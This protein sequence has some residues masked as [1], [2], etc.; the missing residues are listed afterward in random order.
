MHAWYY[1]ENYGIKTLWFGLKC[2]SFPPPLYKNLGLW[3]QPS[4]L[5]LAKIRRQYQFCFVKQMS[6][7]CKRIAFSTQEGGSMYYTKSQGV[8]FVIFSIIVFLFHVATIHACYLN[9]QC[10]KIAISD[11]F[12]NLHFK[13]S[14]SRST[15]SSSCFISWQKVGSEAAVSWNFSRRKLPNWV[16][17][18]VQG[19]QEY[20]NFFV[21]S[22]IKV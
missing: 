19:M 20:T 14:R 2:I 17:V 12:K 8:P 15:C 6:L 9:C 11:F 1:N 16:P 3:N 10:I 4:G 18:Q 5:L 22:F 21:L 7:F 13:G